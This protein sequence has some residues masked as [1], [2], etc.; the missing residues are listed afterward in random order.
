MGL[1][2]SRKIGTSLT[3]GDE[4]QITVIK[5]RGNNAVLHIEADKQLPIRRDELQE[6]ENAQNT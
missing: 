1:V 4:I 3:I 6:L 5:V 2:L